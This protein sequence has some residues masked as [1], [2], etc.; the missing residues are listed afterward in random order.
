LRFRRPDRQTVYITEALSGDL[1]MARMPVASKP[2]Y[3]L[4]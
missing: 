3:G 2:L 1:L 4:E